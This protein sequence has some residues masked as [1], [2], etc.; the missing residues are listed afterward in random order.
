MRRPPSSP[1]Y[2]LWIQQ[3]L[4]ERT[5]TMIKAG[6]FE[7]PFAYSPLINRTTASVPLLFGAGVQDNDVRLGFAMNG[8]QFSVGDPEKTQF[9]FAVGEPASLTA[10]QSHM[11]DPAIV[12]A[13]AL[14]AAVTRWHGALKNLLGGVTSV[15]HHDP[16]HEVFEDGAFPVRVLRRFGWSH[17]LGLGLPDDARSRLRYGPHPSE[18]FAATPLSEPWI[19]HLAEGTDD[20]AAGELR[21]LEA[22]GCLAPN[23][24][25][26]HGVGLSVEDQERVLARRAAVIW[27]PGSNLA[28]LGKTLSPRRL[29][30][31][32][33]LALGSDSRISGGS[34]LLAEMRLAACHSDCAAKELFALVTQAP[35]RLLSMPDVGG[36]A[37]GQ[38]ADLLLVRN[39]GRDPYDTLLHL[40]RSDI[41]AVVRRGEPLLAD[42]D[43]AD[44]FAACGSATTPITLDGKPKL[45]ATHLL[46]RPVWN[47]ALPDRR[48]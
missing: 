19:I 5:K 10:F 4:D 41:R 15:A 28:M 30:D 31:A 40:R 26:A 22:M 45:I 18:S 29:A 9:F 21:D 25:L 23:T 32:G 43:F 20:V 46:K 13:R 34:D 37:Q 8:V 1:S 36:L 16:W 11:T 38:Q 42:P 6:Q 48:Q 7:L 17:S 2:E 47:P 27:C 14:P 24:R 39:T 12:A 33:R 3:V 44:W 35:A